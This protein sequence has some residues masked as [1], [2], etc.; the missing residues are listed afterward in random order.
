MS[1]AEIAF[2][3][4]YDSQGERLS[5]NLFLIND[6]LLNFFVSHYIVPY[7]FF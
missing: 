5:R 1:S 3:N 2:P 6:Q 7:M 4:F